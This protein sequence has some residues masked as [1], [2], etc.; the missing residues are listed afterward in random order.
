MRTKTLLLCLLIACTAWARTESS[1]STATNKV[2]RGF[3]GG[4]MLHTGYLSGRDGNAPRT[5]D[6]RLCSPQG[7]TFGIGGALR[8]NL[9]KH[10]RVGAEGYVSEM[11]SGATDCNDVLKAGSYVR[12]GYGGVLADACWR[13]KKIWP[14]IGASIGGGAMK[15]L[16]ILDGDQHSWS[17]DPNS[18]FHKQAFFYATPYVGLDYCMTQKVHLTFRI[19]WMLAVH[20]SRL[21][22]PTGPRLFVGFMFCH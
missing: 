18:T 21:C 11:P 17:P 4:M 8:V 14:Y 5:T 12:M 13:L 19:D 22:L 6:G 2:Y 9:W 15:G 10:L 7:A 20:N 1:D 3:S 16:Y